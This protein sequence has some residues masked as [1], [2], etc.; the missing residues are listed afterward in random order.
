MLISR[1]DIRKG[2]RRLIDEDMLDSAP[3]D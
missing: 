1:E 3:E 2:E